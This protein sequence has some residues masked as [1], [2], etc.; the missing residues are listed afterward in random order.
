M[1]TISRVEVALPA[2]M[3]KKK[4][5]AYARVSMNSPN[6]LHSLSVQV[7]YYS[8]LIQSNPDWIY[9]GVYADKAGS[10]RLS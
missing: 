5:A 7:S 8:K 2:I 9:A 10:L 4:V 6:L 1:P 3:P